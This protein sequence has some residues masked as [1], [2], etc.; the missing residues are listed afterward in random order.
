MSRPSVGLLPTLEDLHDHDQSLFAPPVRT[1]R[2]GRP[3]LGYRELGSGPAVLLIHGW[4][5][6]S[7]LWRNVMPA[8]AEH[9]RVIAIDLP[10]SAR[11][12]S[13]PTPPT[14]S[15]YFESAIDHS[16]R[17]S[18]SIASRL[19]RHDLGGPVRRTGRSA[20]TTG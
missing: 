10:G 6:S 15:S 9:N 11:R 7:Y 2:A 17:R 3:D 1:V 16:S 20:T 19:P 5:T 18:A 8:L 14:T 4:P 12:T 13:R